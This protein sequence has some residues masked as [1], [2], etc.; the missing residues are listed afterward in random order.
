MSTYRVL[1]ADKIAREGLAPLADDPRFELVERP[2]L[3]GEELAAAIADVDAVLVR[4]ATKIS[5]EA[6]SRATR[7]RVIG[8]AGVGVDTIDVEAAT[9]K[10]VAVMNAPAGNTISAAELAF[11]LLLAVIRKVPAADRSMKAGAWD[12]TS[13]GGME[14]YR[15]TLGLIGAGRV[16]GEVGRRARAFGMRVLAYDPFLSPEAA[17]EIG[18]ELADLDTVLRQADVISL[19]VP[20]TDKTRGMLGDEKLALLK[21]GV[22]IINAARGGVLDEA[23]LL[24]RLG[25]GSIGGAALD[26][27]DQ[28][29]LPADHPLRSLANVVLTPHLGASTEEAQLNVAVEIAEAVRS[30][31]VDG[32]YS[33]A[34][35]AALVGG[36][37]L[38]RL[39]P[40]LDLAERLG[41]VGAAVAG[42]AITAVELRFGGEGDD[43]LRPLAAGAVIGLLSEAVGEGAVNVVNALHLARQRGI[44]VDR[45]RLD[46]PL[47]YADLIELRITHAAGSVRVSGALLGAGHPRLVALDD[48]RLNVLPL[49]QLLVLRNQDVPGVIG[50]VGTLLGNAG[51]N[52]AEYHQARL[53]A[54]GDALAVVSVDA[55]LPDALLGQLRQLP[56]VQQVAQ[57][58]L[59]QAG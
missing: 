40:L 6:L 26:V 4:S 8:R 49:G 43:L 55:P 37:R 16:G 3:K 27:F 10:G 19:H 31:L 17:R 28:E 46:G 36:D 41:R 52:I 23:A 44:K 7:L 35:N 45:T 38:K 50:R 48:F 14:L 25:D 34:V 53:S 33:R 15:K 2:G 59:G 29:P 20:L 58:S 22:I 57:V 21:R 11:A 9:E 56:E 47:D 51:I 32:D 42:G 5:R 30:A 12:R 13:F 54:G 1:V 18:A 39:R 24:R